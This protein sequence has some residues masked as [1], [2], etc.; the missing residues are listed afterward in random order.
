MVEKVIFDTYKREI[1]RYGGE[2][3]IDYAETIFY[4]DSQLVIEILSN[5]NI[6]QEE[7]KEKLYFV[8]IAKIYKLFTDKLENIFKLIDTDQREQYRNDYKT[9]RNVYLRWFEDILNDNLSN[10]DARF[11]N[12]D[13][14]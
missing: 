2:Q 10:I 6:E 11:S 3:L 9:K 12:L 1:N 14:L 13:S 4:L 7:D 8:G 5:F